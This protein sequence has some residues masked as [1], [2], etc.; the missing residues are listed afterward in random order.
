[1]TINAS[2]LSETKSVKQKTTHS[3]LNQRTAIL[4]ILGFTGVLSL[5]PFVTSVLETSGQSL[6]LPIIALQIISVLQSSVLLAAMVLLGAWLA[7][8]VK[9]STPLIDLYCLKK[10]T[11][12]QPIESG[13]DKHAL[14]KDTLKFGVLGGILAGLLLVMISH[15]FMSALPADFLSNAEKMSLPVVTRLLYGGITE[16]LL[17]RWG[18]MSF[19]VWF[20]YFLTQKAQGKL[21]H[22]HYIVGIVLSSLLFAAGHLPAAGALTA[23]VTTP[24]LTYIMLG[25]VVFGLIAGYLFWKKGLECAIFAHITA[26]I[27]MLT[28][29]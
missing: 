28:V 19:F 4:F 26:H 15:L 2:L 29:L 8:K 9:L 3:I 7:P 11:S 6:P 21:K 5:I 16:E 24:L 17:L 18:I 27:V 10:H 13:I 1:M 20:A 23:T 12:T 25:N 14:L 22:Y